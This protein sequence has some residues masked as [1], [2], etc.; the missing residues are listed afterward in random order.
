MVTAITPGGVRSRNQSTSRQFLRGL[1]FSL[2][3]SE[4]EKEL[5]KSS[6]DKFFSVNF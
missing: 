2:E 4:I 6:I 1:F 5:L 3:F